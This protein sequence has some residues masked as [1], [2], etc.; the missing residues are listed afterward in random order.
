MTIDLTH[1]DPSDYTPKDDLER[2]AVAVPDAV[3][4]DQHGT[5]TRWSPEEEDGYRRL[6][7]RV[8]DGLRNG[9]DR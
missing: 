7:A 5:P 6:L 8:L 4:H 1:L 2:R 3:Y 9:D